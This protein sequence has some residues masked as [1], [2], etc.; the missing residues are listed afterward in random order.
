MSSGAPA[1][2]SYGALGVAAFAAVVALV[3]ARISYLAYK[4]AGPRIRLRVEPGTNEPASGRV[5]I[6]FTVENR[7]RGDVSIVSFQVT[8]YGERKPVLEIEQIEG[9]FT[10]PHRLPGNSQ[11]TWFGNVLEVM[12]RYDAG[13]RDRSIKPYSSWPS[14]VYFSVKLGSGKYAHAKREQFDSRALIAGA[15]P[16]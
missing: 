8:P 12:R 15:F 9:A 5:M 16:D 7:G 10:L 11:E 14:Q 6:K 3:S 4:A 1:W 2:V 13:L